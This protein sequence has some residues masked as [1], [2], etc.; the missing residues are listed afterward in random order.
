MQPRRS[1]LR[2]CLSITV[3][4][5]VIAGGL[6]AFAQLGAPAAAPSAA[7]SA[8][9]AAPAKVVT[10]NG[11]DGAGGTIDPIN[12][13]DDYTART[14]VVAKVHP[15]ERVTLISRSGKGVQIETSTGVRGWVSASFINE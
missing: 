6:F 13:W 15:G 10:M 4:V 5:L 2:Y 8:P 11:D 9:A 7:T 12:V 14:Q 3:L 1:P